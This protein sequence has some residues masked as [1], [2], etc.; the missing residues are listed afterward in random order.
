MENQKKRPGASSR[1]TLVILDLLKHSAYTF[2]FAAVILVCAVAL[3]YLKDWMVKADRPDWLVAGTELLSIWMFLTDGIVILIVCGKLIKEVYAEFIPI[4]K[5]A[6]FK[7]R[8]RFWTYVI[9]SLPYLPVFCGM[10]LI[11]CSSTDFHRL[12]MESI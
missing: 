4:S 5:S 9:Y 1:K 11:F 2:L 10:L 7:V 3:S 8:R 6:R 12:I